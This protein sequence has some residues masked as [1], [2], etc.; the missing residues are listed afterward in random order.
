MK[1]MIALAFTCFFL[2]SHGNAQR[3]KLEAE[4]TSNSS[5]QH[6]K[7][8]EFAYK[9]P[10][11][12]W[13]ERVWTTTFWVGQSSQKSVP[14]SSCNRKSAWERNWVQA[15]GGYD[16]P[17]RRAGFRPAAF[18]PKHNPFYVALPYNDLKDPADASR[19]IP[20]WQPGVGRWT[21]QVKGRWLAIQHNGRTAYAQWK[22]VG[23]WVTHDPEY[24]FGGKKHRGKAGLDVSPAVRD[25][26]GL[27]GAGY[28][29]WRFVEE[30][31]VPDGPWL[32]YGDAKQK[33]L[34]AIQR[35]KLC[36]TNDLQKY[37]KKI[38]NAC[39]KV[40]NKAYSE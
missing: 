3:N 36:M 33:I 10:A 28:T 30:H 11:Y 7:K 13:R 1:Q 5:R 17:T 38:K 15:F 27:K 24:V 18:Y 39:F 4:T 16:H 23:P 37:Q 29:R 9:H 20:W 21:S 31:E 26:L 25:Y 32:D 22:D 35:Y 12:S 19:W 40:A 6:P 14:G 34:A 8:A 2:V